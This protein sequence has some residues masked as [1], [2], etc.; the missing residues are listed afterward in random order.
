MGLLCKPPLR[1]FR[2][3]FVRSAMREELLCAHADWSRYVRTKGRSDA[4]VLRLLER[5]SRHV[6][7]GRGAVLCGHGYTPAIHEFAIRNGWRL[8]QHG[9]EWTLTPPTAAIP[10]PA[11][12]PP[13]R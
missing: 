7:K 4:R 6:M 8:R 1:W 12:A 3:V 9:D 11:P 2:D 13:V 10:R 5:K